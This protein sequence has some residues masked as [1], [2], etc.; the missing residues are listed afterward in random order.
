M[1]VAAIIKKIK[2]IILLSDI[3]K[4]E[5]YEGKYISLNQVMKHL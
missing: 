3:P 4:A 2:L 1:I 5:M